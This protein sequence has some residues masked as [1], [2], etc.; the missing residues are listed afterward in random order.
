VD[1]RLACYLRLVTEVS[2]N[3]VT[4]NPCAA[5]DQKI[6]IALFTCD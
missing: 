6:E 4:G 5:L 3:M 1:G 2:S